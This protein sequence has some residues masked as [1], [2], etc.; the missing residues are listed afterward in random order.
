M[1]F[2]GGPEGKNPPAE[3]GAA[4]SIPTSGRSPGEGSDGNPL[5]CSY[6]EGPMD[7]GS[8]WSAVHRVAESQIRLNDLTTSVESTILQKLYFQ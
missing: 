7:R 1:G 5:Q 8:R 4:G 6:L 2:P 3:A